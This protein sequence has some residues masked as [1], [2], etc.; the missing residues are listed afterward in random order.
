[1]LGGETLNPC[2]GNRIRIGMPV[3]THPRKRRESLDNNLLTTKMNQLTLMVGNERRASLLGVE[4]ILE[5]C[6]KRGVGDVRFFLV[7]GRGLR[8]RAGIWIQAEAAKAHLNQ[9]GIISGRLV[10]SLQV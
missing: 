2:A 1:M 10:K 8:L 6:E 9:P 4:A 7:L 5:L 3:L